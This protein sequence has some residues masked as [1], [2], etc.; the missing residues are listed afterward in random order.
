[1]KSRFRTR[2]NVSASGELAAIRN[3]GLER[4][5]SCPAFGVLGAVPSQIAIGDGS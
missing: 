3:G 4:Q 2:S 1:M 5:P